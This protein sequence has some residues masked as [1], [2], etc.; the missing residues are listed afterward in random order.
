VKP[1][2][3]AIAAAAAVAVA[4]EEEK[5]RKWQETL[6]AAVAGTEAADHA[7]LRPNPLYN[8]G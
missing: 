4:E 8:N 5:E 6:Q 1:A 2:A 7:A 3:T